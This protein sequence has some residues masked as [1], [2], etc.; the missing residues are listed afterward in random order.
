MT[1]TMRRQTP[2]LHLVKRQHQA[3]DRILGGSNLRRRHLCEI[4]LLQHLAV[5]DCETRVGLELG[6]FVLGLS[7]I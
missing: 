5:R 7:D 2:C 6:R 4:F 1:V 3:L